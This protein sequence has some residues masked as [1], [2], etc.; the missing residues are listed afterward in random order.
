MATP[1]PPAYFELSWSILSTIGAANVLFGL[2]VIG[3]TS[4]SQITVVPIVSSAAGSVA[5]GLCFYAFYDQ[6]HSLKNKATASAFGDVFWMIQ[7]VGLSFYSYALLRKILKDRMWKVFNTLF[8]ATVLVIVAVRIMIAVSRVRYILKGNTRIQDTVNSL[9][10]SYFVLIASLECLSAFFLLKTFTQVKSTSDRAA[11]KAGF[12]RYLM[13][14]TEVRLATLAV[15]GTMRAVTYSF[16]MTAQSATN[17]ASQLDRF[18][19]A[20]ECLFPSVMFID[21]LASKL[22]FTA[23][24]YDPTQSRRSYLRGFSSAVKLGENCYDGTQQSERLVEIHG[25]RGSSQENASSP[26]PPGSVA[27]LHGGEPGSQG[28]INK[29]VVISVRHSISSSPNRPRHCLTLP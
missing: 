19:Y 23:Q 3:I 4:F 22:V 9:H 16:Q 8:W 20:L 24:G 27:D 21:I 1:I 10:V 25:G 12:F 11:S 2:L 15:L 26:S 5:N 18:A 13:R 6:N 28:G 7:E 17:V 14:S 29:T